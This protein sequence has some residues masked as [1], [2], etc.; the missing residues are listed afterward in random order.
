MNKMKHFFRKIAFVLFGALMLTGCDLDQ[1]DNYTFSYGLSY[2]VKEEEQQ[3]VLKD[4]FNSKLDFEKSYSYHG[5]Y[6]DATVFGCDKFKEDIKV[7]TNDEVLA[8]LGK[9]DQASLALY[10]YSSKGNMGPVSAVYWLH[11]PNA[12]K[13]EEGE[14]GEDPKE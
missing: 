10:M 9:D 6:Y 14:G 2:T 4:Y 8:L 13:G 12:E 1:V 11:D 3:K 5:S 7:F